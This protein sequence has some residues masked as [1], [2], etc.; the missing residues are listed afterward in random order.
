MLLF[1]ENISQRVTEIL[2]SEYPHSKH[3]KQF[4]LENSPDSAIWEQAKSEG[5]AII[6]KDN[7]FAQTVLVKGHPP[8]VI[9]IAI[10]N[11]STKQIVS[12]LKLRTSLIKSFV[13]DASES[14]LILK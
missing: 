1:D 13:N 11:C 9:I 4:A 2:A 7:D 10:G 12:F 8:K 6:S 5:L 14:L 3:V